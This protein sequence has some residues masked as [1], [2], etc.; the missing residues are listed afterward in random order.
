MSEKVN[1]DHLLPEQ[2][3]VIIGILKAR[4]ETNMIRHEGIPGFT[5]GMRKR[6]CFEIV[7]ST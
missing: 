6:N 4:F 2:R 1:K 5:Q 7:L 3:D